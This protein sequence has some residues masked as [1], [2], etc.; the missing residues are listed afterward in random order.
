M[1]PSF[2]ESYAIDLYYLSC[3][4]K[5]PN[6][7]ILFQRSFVESY[8]PIYIIFCIE[9]WNRNQDIYSNIREEKKNYQTN[10]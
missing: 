5:E 7:K 2:V 8:A 9:E 1:Q 10:S 6:S 4:R 3:R